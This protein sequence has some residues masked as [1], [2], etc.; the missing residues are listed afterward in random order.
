MAGRWRKL[1]VRIV[2]VRFNVVRWSIGP[3]Q[4]F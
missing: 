4:R 2:Q 3:T 1:R